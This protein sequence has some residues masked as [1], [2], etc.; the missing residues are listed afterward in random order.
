MLKRYTEAINGEYIVKLAIYE[1]DDCKIEMHESWPIFSEKEGSHYCRECAFV[2]GIINDK[3][4]LFACGI[5]NDNYHVD[6]A[7]D[8]DPIIW[9]GGKTPPW[10]KS[11]REIRNSQEYKMWRIEVFERDG[12]ICQHCNQKGGKL[13]AHHIKEFSKYPDERFN[14]DNGLTL[15]V[16]CHREV[17]KKR[18]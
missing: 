6:I 8:G 10:D 1:C 2:R 12:Y 7:P 9:T 13:T 5:S 15:C 18:E 14:L 17:H 3:E 11:N 4:F 16:K